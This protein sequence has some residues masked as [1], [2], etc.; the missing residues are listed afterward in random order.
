[1]EHT[2]DRSIARQIALDHLAENRNYY[3]LL[4]RMEKMAKA[5]KTLSAAQKKALAHGRAVLKAK[6]IA[7]GKKNPKAKK[8]M[9]ALKGYASILAANKG[10]LGKLASQYKRL[11]I[12]PLDQEKP[13]KKKVVKKP[14]RN[15][16]AVSSSGRANLFGVTHEFPR[17][18][19][20]PPHK[21]SR[22]SCRHCGEFHTT[23]QH[24]AHAVYGHG[25]V[26]TKIVPAFA[27][28]HKKHSGPLSGNIFKGAMKTYGKVR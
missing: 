14:S 9:G 12:V 20:H 19:V 25:K 2:S 21:K 17:A 15:R 10:K 8:P 4:K 5:K 24:N 11:G 18:S 28:T 3:R 13:A 26:V 7:K 1:M 6:H 16:G 22:P 27:L 23:S